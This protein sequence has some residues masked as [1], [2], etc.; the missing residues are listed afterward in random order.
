MSTE[1]I[2]AY[3]EDIAL[4]YG[5]KLIGAVVV[6]VVGS[7]VIKLLVG[8][9]RKSM[10]KRGTDETLQPFFA[11]LVKSMLRVMLI[12]SVLSMMGVAMTSFIAILGHAVILEFY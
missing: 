6:W 3:A 1:Q 7:W 4:T 11:G 2:I 12:I 9:F 5:P 8:Q 10:V